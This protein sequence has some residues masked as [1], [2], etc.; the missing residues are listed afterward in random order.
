MKPRH[1]VLTTIFLLLISSP[2]MAQSTASRIELG[3]QVTTLTLFDEAGGDVTEPGF[4]GRITYNVNR[5]LA[6]EAEGNFFPNKNVFFGLGG[7]RA[8]QG[9][10]G[11][12]VGQ[13]FSKFGVFGKVRPGF[14]SVGDVLSLE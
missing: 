9:Q 10:F 1:P 2:T 14:L 5:K 11:V 8:V 4:G 7:G 3:P 13:R 6:F 12:K